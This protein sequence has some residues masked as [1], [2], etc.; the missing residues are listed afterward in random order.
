MSKENKI[1]MEKINGTV[2]RCLDIIK[3]SLGNLPDYVE[4][5]LFYQLQELLSEKYDAYGY[6]IQMG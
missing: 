2:V 1:Y 3:Y 5:R 6:E 4:D